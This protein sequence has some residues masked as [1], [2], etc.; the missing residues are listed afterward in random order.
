MLYITSLAAPYHDFTICNLHFAICAYDT[1]P[2]TVISGIL[3]VGW[4]SLTGEP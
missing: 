2:P 4:A 3:S 1:T